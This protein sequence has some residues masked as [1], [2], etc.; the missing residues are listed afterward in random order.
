MTDSD[1][2]EWYE[3]D[4]PWDTI[5]E[6]EARFMELG[7]SKEWLE[8]VEEVSRSTHATEDEVWDGMAAALRGYLEGLE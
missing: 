8:L 1:R 3:L 6:S 7:Q 5:G 2:R 4:A